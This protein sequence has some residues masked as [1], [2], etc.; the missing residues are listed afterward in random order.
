[1]TKWHKYRDLKPNIKSIIKSKENSQEIVND[2]KVKTHNERL[3]FILNNDDKNKLSS[4]EILNRYKEFS[5]LHRSLWIPIDLAYE[6]EIARDSRARDDF[7]L[8]LK[9]ILVGKIKDLIERLSVVVTSDE[10]LWMYI[11]RIEEVLKNDE[12]ECKAKVLDIIL[13]DVYIT[14]PDKTLTIEND[15]DHQSNMWLKLAIIKKCGGVRTD[16]LKVVASG[17]TVKDM[18]SQSQSRFYFVEKIKK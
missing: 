4:E 2:R 8:E 3:L 10:I 6:N 12:I 16:N 1:M 18:I 17:R 5:T 13:S 11:T 9:L 14:T 7:N 15:L